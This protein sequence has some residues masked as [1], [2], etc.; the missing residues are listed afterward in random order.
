MHRLI[1]S[2]VLLLSLI[3]CTN[4]FVR[5]YGFSAPDAESVRGP[6]RGNVVPDNAPSVSQGFHPEKEDI[7]SKEEAGH[8][9]IDILGKTGTPV[10]SPADGV[11]IKS[12]YAPF[13]GN[14]IVISHGIDERGRYIQSRLVHLDKRHVKVGET[15]VRGQQIGELGST[16]ML[17]HFPHLHFEIRAGNRSD[18]AVSEPVNPH[19]YWVKGAGL[20]TCFDRAVKWA[21]EPLRLTYPVPCKGVQWQLD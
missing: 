13:F 8:E 20:V 2:L 15:V 12:H 1:I 7:N 14:R 5:P 10:I 18:Q 4:Y 3:G 19:I 9:G 16:G 6:R 21:K 11:V 17:A